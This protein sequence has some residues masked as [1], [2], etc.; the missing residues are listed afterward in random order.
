[1]KKNH[2]SHDVDQQF[3]DHSGGLCLRRWDLRDEYERRAGRDGG[4]RRRCGRAAE[5]ERDGKDCWRF[6]LKLNEKP[7]KLARKGLNS[8]T[9]EPCAFEAKLVSKTVRGLP[10]EKLREMIN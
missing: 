3:D 1:M 7:A 2:E 6:N 9:T 8:I 10:M 5:A 4:H